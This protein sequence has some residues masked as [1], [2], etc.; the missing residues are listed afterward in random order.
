MEQG[1]SIL[2]AGREKALARSAYCEA[3]RSFEQALSALAHLPEKRETHE[4]AI[5]LRLTLRSALSPLGNIGRIL[6]CLREAQS[7]AEALDPI[8]RPKELQACYLP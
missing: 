7:L 5:D 4:Q 8:R 2:A 1:S 6:A 3:V